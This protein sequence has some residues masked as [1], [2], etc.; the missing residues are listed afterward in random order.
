MRNPESTSVVYGPCK[1]GG[2]GIVYDER[3]ERELGRCHDSVADVDGRYR[4]RLDVD[5]ADWHFYVL[6]DALGWY[7]AHVYDGAPDAENPDWV[8]DAWEALADALVGDK[9]ARTRWEAV[10]R[11]LAEWGSG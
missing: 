2:H 6:L 8:D 3:M 4:P 9:D 11:A 7:M 5:S 10:D 1:C